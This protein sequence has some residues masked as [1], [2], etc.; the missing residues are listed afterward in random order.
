MEKQERDNLYVESL[1]SFIK[2][3]DLSLK[4]TK[5]GISNT[6]FEMKHY[7]NLVKLEKIYL[8]QLNSRIIDAKK[9][10]KEY[11]STTK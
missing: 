6:E 8:N 1:K 5:R 4:K 11:L 2:I 9:T 3:G 10:L 7:S